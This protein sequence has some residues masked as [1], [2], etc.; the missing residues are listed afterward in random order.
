MKQQIKAKLSKLQEWAQKSNNAVKIK[1]IH[2]LEQKLA[3]FTETSAVR[4]LLQDMLKELETREEVVKKVEDEAKEEMSSHF[5]KLI[6]Y[7]KEVVDLS[8]SADKAKEKSAETDM[9]REKLNGLKKNAAESYHDEHEQ[10]ETVA[11]PAE[12]AIYILQV[13][14]QLLH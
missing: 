3:S 6:E 14:P 1:G 8:N 2:S 7:E 5:D 12:R 9:H 13:F 4:Q 10:Y 11:P